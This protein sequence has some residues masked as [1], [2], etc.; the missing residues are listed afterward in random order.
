[1]EGLSAQLRQVGGHRVFL[2]VGWWCGC[3]TYEWDCAYVGA[4]GCWAYRVL[5]LCVLGICGGVFHSGCSSCLFFLS[6]VFLSS[7]LFLSWL[8]PYRAGLAFLPNGV[9]FVSFGYLF[10]VVPSLRGCLLFLWL[11]LFC[12][13]TS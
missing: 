11:V 6:L 13:E 8:L 1:M 4:W 2:T 12:G 10:V 3:F 5:C 9:V 7:C